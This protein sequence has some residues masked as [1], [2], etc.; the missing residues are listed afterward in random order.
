MTAQRFS[1]RTSHSDW[2]ELKCLPILCDFWESFS[3]Q[4]PGYSLMGCVDFQS[5][6][7]SQTF[8]KDSDLWSCAFFVVF[9]LFFL[10]KTTLPFKFQLSQPLG[11]LVSVS[12]TQL[13][14][15]LCLGLFSKYSGNCLH[16]ESW[17]GIQP[18]M[19]PFSQAS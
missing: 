14:S 10:K 7:H 4:L 6:Y 11:M 13:I 9:C 19:L 1:L 18:H 3:L 2:S 16:T 5:M 17:G 8:S 15:S 12:S